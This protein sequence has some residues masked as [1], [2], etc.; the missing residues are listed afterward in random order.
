MA[1]VKRSVTRVRQTSAWFVANAI[2]LSFM[3][4]EWDR[5]V[6]PAVATDG[7]DP[8]WDRNDAGAIG[9]GGSNHPTGVFVSHALA[10]D[11]HPTHLTAFRAEADIR[12][13]QSAVGAPQVS[14]TSANSAAAGW[15][16]GDF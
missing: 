5:A 10:T 1:K 14:D 4:E 7:D 3:A 6:T 8:F 2:V 13:T 9:V 12:T 15:L 16:L 11:E